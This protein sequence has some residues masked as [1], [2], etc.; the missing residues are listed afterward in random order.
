MPSS[1]CRTSHPCASLR[2]ASTG[3]EVAPRG[4]KSA[5][6]LAAAPAGDAPT[7]SNRWGVAVLDL[8]PPSPAVC[9]WPPRRS[10][11]PPLPR[12]SRSS[13]GISRWS[14]VGPRTP[15]GPTAPTSPALLAGL[16]ACRAR[17]RAA[18]RL[19]RRRARRRGSAVHARPQ[20]AAA[21]T[22]TRMG[23]QDGALLPV[24]P[25]AGWSPRGPVAPSRPCS[26]ASRPPRCSTRRGSRAGQDDP[27]AIRDLLVVELLYATGMRVAELCGLDLDDVDERAP[28]AARARQGRPGADRRLRRPRRPRSAAGGAPRAARTRP[29]RFAARAAARRPREAAST[30]GSPAVWCTGPW[31]PSRTSRTSARTAF[32]TRRRRTCSTAA[33]TFVT[34]RSCSVTLSYRRL[35]STRMSP[36]SG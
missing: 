22:F 13:S 24:D 26:T 1:S 27:L 25:G 4:A 30:R 6:H 28:R 12:C 35:S 32:G 20:A 29:T 17:S 33:R 36:S 9:R 3:C 5:L 2:T 10:S 8:G 19:A 31:R 16:R 7:V 18:A 11:G 23:T 21:R 15:C 34:Y 14:G